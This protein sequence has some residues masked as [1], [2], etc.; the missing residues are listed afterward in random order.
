MNASAWRTKFDL[1]RLRCAPLI[2]FCQWTLTR[3][4]V[5]CL[6]TTVCWGQEALFFLHRELLL[7]TSTS[8]DYR[9]TAFRLRRVFT[10][11]FTNS[12]IHSFMHSF[13]S[14]FTNSFTNQWYLKYFRAA[15]GP[16]IKKAIENETKNGSLVT[17]IVDFRFC[18]FGLGRRQ[19]TA[20]KTTFGSRRQPTASLAAKIRQHLK[21]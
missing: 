21:I 15:R 12:F 4:A 3:V 9:K 14:S 18:S 6:E 20:M 16:F 2:V 11:S 7:T 19:P 8:G 5:C 17:T 13:T 1:H 10:K